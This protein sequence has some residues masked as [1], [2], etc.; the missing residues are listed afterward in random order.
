MSVE[1]RDLLVAAMIGNPRAV[2]LALRNGIPVDTC[3]AHSMTP[4]HHAATQEI[5]G[6]RAVV[7]AL[8]AARAD[9]NAADRHGRT[10]LH[11]AVAAG[12]ATLARALV[13]AG[14]DRR[15]QDR[16]NKTPAA[17][18]R[19]DSDT[20]RALAEAGPGPVWCPASHAT[21]PP[22]ARRFVRTLLLAALRGARQSADTAV[23]GVRFATGH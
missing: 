3:D 10:P 13:H 14:A 6:F 5:A 2:V 8:L 18:A 9:P 12:A 22:A 23:L 11:F 16:R 20:A 15:R 4:L 19:P 1:A 17:A 7:A 21:Y